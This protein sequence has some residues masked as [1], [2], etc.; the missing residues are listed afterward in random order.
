MP[1]VRVLRTFRHGETREVCRRGTVVEVSTAM[2]KH[3]VAQGY[4]ESVQGDGS[5]A[6]ARPAR[7]AAARQAENGGETGEPEGAA[8]QEG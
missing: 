7:N 4:A 8:E 6:A 1:K 5:A 2:A 3:L